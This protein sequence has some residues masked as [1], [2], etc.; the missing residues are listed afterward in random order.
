MGAGVAALLPIPVRSAR[1]GELRVLDLGD[2]FLFF[3]DAVC[4]CDL[5]VL[6][7]FVHWNWCIKAMRST[8]CQVF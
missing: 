3:V 1:E 5:Q 7:H 6:R 8:V 2:I 4:F